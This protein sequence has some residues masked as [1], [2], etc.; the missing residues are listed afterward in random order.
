[1]NKYIEGIEWNK[2]Q[3]IQGYAPAVATLVL[4]ALVTGKCIPMQ[5]VLV[6]SD[7][8]IINARKKIEAAFTCPVF[9]RYGLGEEVASA[10]E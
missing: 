1:M 5:A 7:C 8:L 6:S 3:Y 4:H 10:I 2:L 9:E